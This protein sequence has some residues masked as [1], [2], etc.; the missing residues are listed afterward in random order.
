L[1]NI[2]KFRKKRKKGEKKRKKAWGP[3]F[4]LSNDNVNKE[5]GIRKRE[6][7]ED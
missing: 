2:F 4:S 5:A 6:E 7:G 3:H 1:K